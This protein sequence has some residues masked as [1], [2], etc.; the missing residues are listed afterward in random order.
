M[1]VNEVILA[2]D[3]STSAT[4]ALLFTTSGELLD[5]ESVSHEQIYPQPGWVEHDAN[6]IYQ[7]TIKAVS[8]LLSRNEV[9]VSELL[10]LSI[11]N[12]RETAVIFDRETGK[13]VANAIVWQCRRGEALCKELEKAGEGK[14]I[15]QS[16]GLKVDTYFSA[17]KLRWLVDNN[18]E[19]EKRLNDGSALIGTIDT[20]LIYRLTKGAVFATDHTNACRTLLFDIKNLKWDEKLTRLF[21]VPIS[22]LAEVRESSAHFGETTIE[23]VLD[24]PIPI[25][26]VMGD[27]QAA[28]FAQR[29]FDPGGSKVT[30]G[31]GSSVLLNIGEDPVMSSSGIVTTIGWVHNQ[32]PVYALEGITN[33]TGA[34]IAWICNQLELL[35]SPADSEAHAT[36]IPDTNGVY[37]VPAFVGLGAPYWEP[38]VRG[39]ILGL[40]PGSTR[41]HVVRAGLE[42]IAYRIRDVLAMMADEAGLPLQFIHADGGAV[43]NRFLMQ[44]TADMLGITVRVSSLPELSALGA[45]FSGL[46]G[47]GAVQTTAALL[48]LPIESIDFEPKMDREKADTYY[49]GWKAAV[50]KV[51]YQPIQG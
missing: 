19:I 11:T 24:R 36:S 29:C 43:A 15:Q 17:P 30:F 33:F 7:N 31:T 5:K 28:L 2:I 51:L 44:F 47:I 25:C 18:P 40:T 37:L 1:N 13:P 50:Q 42:G 12:Q 38:G 34:T 48:Q 10:C 46:L 39:A 16:T 9:L 8:S 4:K 45:V 35:E 6:E 27:S 49:S 41:A 14:Y 32:K 20:Y 21:H 22:A 26:G 3:Q 23:D